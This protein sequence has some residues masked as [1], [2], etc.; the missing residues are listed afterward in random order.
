MYLVIKLGVIFICSNKQL[1]VGEKSIQH[2]IAIFDVAILYT[3]ADSV[4]CLST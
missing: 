1:G 2:S 3:G 4:S